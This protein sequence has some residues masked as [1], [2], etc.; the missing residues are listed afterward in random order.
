MDDPPPAAAGDR[1]AQDAGTAS[2]V[3]LPVCT[4]WGT[5]MAY[6]P[7][8]EEQPPTDPA[9][10]SPEAFPD[11]AISRDEDVP[12]HPE[13]VDT[14]MDAFGAARTWAQREAA[15]HFAGVWIDND[16]QAAVIAFTDGVDRYA[17]EVRDRFGAGWWVVEAEHAYAELEEVQEQVSQAPAWGSGSGRDAPAD[18]F[19]GA[20]TPPGS[21]V[22]SGLSE[23]YGEVSVTVVGGDDGAL[24]EL[25]AELDHPAICF[26]VLPP[27]PDPDVDGPVRTLATAS[28]W[29]DDLPDTDLL[30][31]RLEIAYDR[32]TAERA[33]AENV[34]D[35]L[36]PGDGDPSAD[37]LHAGLDT[38][39]WDAEVVAVYTG[40]RSGSC[41]VWIADVRVE[42]GGVT[43]EE[44]SPVQGACTDDYN[45][46]RTVLVIDRDRVPAPDEL[47]LPLNDGFPEESDVTLYPPAG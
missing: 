40:G 21:I 3:D 9:I 16:H 42:G 12:D 39:D 17:A 14:S 37:A 46:F 27:P 15:D 32:E 30:Y 1:D 43:A 7:P 10:T 19:D 18:G 26:E 13:G 34:P 47:P 38:V 29:R 44:A 11:I 2:A 23:M 5:P 22:G 8:P 41:P 36:P 35:D 24:A 20:A 25:A 33:F 31:A 45:S 28:G 6:T 4:E